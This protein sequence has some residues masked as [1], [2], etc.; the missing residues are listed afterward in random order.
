MSALWA[1]WDRLKTNHFLIIYYSRNR[2]IQKWLNKVTIRNG[3]IRSINI[4]NEDGVDLIKDIDSAMQNDFDY[5]DRLKS[6]VSIWNGISKPPMAPKDFGRRSSKWSV[7]LKPQIDSKLSSSFNKLPSFIGSS[8]NLQ[9]IKHKEEPKISLAKIAS[10]RYNKEVAIKSQSQNKILQNTLELKPNFENSIMIDS[11]LSSTF[12]VE[13]DLKQTKEDPRKQ[14]A[15]NLKFISRNELQ[16][17]L[18]K[19]REESRNNPNNLSILKALTNPNFKRRKYKKISYNTNGSPEKKKVM[20]LG[21]HIF[22][23]DKSL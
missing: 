2:K 7:L 11:K 16:Q 15:I 6:D 12:W 13:D 17:K 19:I 1:R 8:Q 14:K 21:H 3:L 22:K 23:S 4:T 9:T 18:S 20:W 10:I 5:F